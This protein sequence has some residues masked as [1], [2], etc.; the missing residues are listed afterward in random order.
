VQTAIKNIRT[1]IVNQTM[2]TNKRMPYP[3]KIHLNVSVAFSPIIR[4]LC[5]NTGKI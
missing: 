3:I 2:Y 1:N 4:L 5:K